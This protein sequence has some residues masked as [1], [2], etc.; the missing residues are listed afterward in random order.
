MVQYWGLAGVFVGTL[1]SS[2]AVPNWYRPIV[3][4]KYVFDSSVIDYFKRF[5]F[6]SLIL[7]LNIFITSSIQTYFFS[8]INLLNFVINMFLCLIIPNLFIISV[9]YKTKDFKKSKNIILNQLKGAKIWRR[10]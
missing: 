5:F 10:K 6:Y 3:V 7:I 1:A 2:V 9:F 4:Y 8:D